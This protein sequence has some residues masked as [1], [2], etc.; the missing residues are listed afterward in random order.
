MQPKERLLRRDPAGLQQL[1]QIIA[2][3]YSHTPER[4]LTL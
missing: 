4:K 2:A 3:A 1:S